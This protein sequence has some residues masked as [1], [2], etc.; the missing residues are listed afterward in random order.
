MSCAQM[1]QETCRYPTYLHKQR[2]LKTS[3]RHTAGRAQRRS[4]HALRQQPAVLAGAI[5][6]IVL[7]GQRR[8]VA[9]GYETQPQLYW[10]PCHDGHILKSNRVQHLLP[11]RRGGSLIGA[12]FGCKDDTLRVVKRPHLLRDG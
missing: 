7:H 5:P 1:L 2:P 6:D 10:V 11:G 9:N 8:A 12:H 3:F 4:G